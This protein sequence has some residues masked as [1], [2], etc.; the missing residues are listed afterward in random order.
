M[1][2][3]QS[4][5]ADRV[6]YV[7]G[8]PHLDNGNH[9]I[10][11]DAQSALARSKVCVDNRAATCPVIMILPTELHVKNT[12]LTCTEARPASLEGF[13]EERLV[14]SCP[15]SNVNVSPSSGSRMGPSSE[16]SIRTADGDD[17]AL[18]SAMA[19]V[20]FQCS[21]QPEVVS[22]FCDVLA[23]P[24]IGSQE[25]PSAGSKGHGA[26]VC[27]P[28]A[29]AMKGCSTGKDCKFCHLCE[30][31][32]KKR[33]KKEKKQVVREATRWRKSVAESWRHLHMSARSF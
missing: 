5:P 16:V 9:D 12:F 30:N 25:C 14:R 33:R 1:P 19:A 15:A 3:V 17:E 6:L 13:Y 18:L 22:D 8:E 10:G 23:A 7:N 2:E 20:R 24:E 21:R 31:G 29:F 11:S 32:E 4:D 27:K 26:G 28:C